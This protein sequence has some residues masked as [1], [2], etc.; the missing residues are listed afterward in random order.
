MEKII[1]RVEYTSLPRIKK[2]CKKCGGK[3][4]F[5]S[6]ELFRVNAN[7]KNLD[8]WLIYNCSACKTTWKQELY[9][10]VKYNY[11]TKEVLEKFHENDK[12]LAYH[13]TMDCNH[14]SKTG[15]EVLVPDY[16]VTGKDIDIYSGDGLEK[17]FEI[18]ITADYQFDIKIMSVLKEKL[19]ISNSRLDN[20]IK[21]N[22]II[23]N[24]NRQIKKCKLQK[25][26]VIYL[27]I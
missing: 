19:R 2:Y 7:Q 15:F 17:N 25:E 11:F 5:L 13:Y 6:S 14:L 23:C 4:E 27:T 16:T 9:S 22:K 26:Q 1:W 12:E 21:N 8:V 20:M 3:S 10:R 18:Y 24:M